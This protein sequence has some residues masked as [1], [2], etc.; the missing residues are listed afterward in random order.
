M[1]AGWCLLM[2]GQV[3]VIMSCQQVGL[4]MSWRQVGV[5]YALYASRGAAPAFKV[6][7]HAH[8]LAPASK[9]TGYRQCKLV[10]SIDKTG[11]YG[12]DIGSF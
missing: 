9:V 12:V 3:G 8:W 2:H 7:A 1:T 5:D 11:N 10:C 4:I 6:I